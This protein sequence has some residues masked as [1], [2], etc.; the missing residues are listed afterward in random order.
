MIPGLAYTNPRRYCA[1]T[2]GVGNSATYNY[3]NS[4]TKHSLGGFVGTTRN[5]QHWYRDP[6]GA[7]ICGGQTFNTSNAMQIMILP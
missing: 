5:F 3:D 6:M 1:I 2:C 4:D 7:G